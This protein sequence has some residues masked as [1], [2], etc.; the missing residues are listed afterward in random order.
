MSVGTAK[1]WF[2]RDRVKIQGEVRRLRNPS[3]AEF[4]RCIGRRE[5]VVVTDAFAGQPVL[6][7]W[8]A[9]YLAEKA[10]AT[11]W[12]IL[13][14]RYGQFPGGPW[15]RVDKTLYHA[16]IRPLSES[17]IRVSGTSMLPPIAWQGEKCYLYQVPLNLFGD[18]AEDIRVPS[19]V[20]FS[21]DHGRIFVWIGEA[22]NITP[23][24]IDFEENL[25]VQVTGAKEVLLW[26]ATQ[27][28]FHY[29]HPFGTPHEV[30]SQVDVTD[31][32]MGRF[33]EFAQAQALVARLESGDAL[34][35]PFDCL[36]CV[37]SETP[38]ISVNFWWGRNA[39][40]RMMRLAT[41]PLA[42]YCLRTPIHFLKA[43]MRQPEL[44]RIRRVLN[45]P[46]PVSYLD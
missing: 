31:P 12:E 10:G 42:Q 20:P 28:H 35:I 1:T 26:N 39:T 22:G 33:P 23:T 8:S 2:A 25:L 18:A 38:A 5:P 40:Y 9:S 29:L 41:S 37:R 4:A 45:W 13:V 6:R 3:A 27:F 19:F 36:H 16:T 46:K 24:H 43:I 44:S 17:L 30:H 14:A 11:P 15:E 21:H 32:D 7:K 34:Y